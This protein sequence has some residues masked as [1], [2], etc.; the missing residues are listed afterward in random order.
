[1]CS[2]GTSSFLSPD[3]LCEARRLTQTNS[4]GCCLCP[5]YL[6]CERLLTPSE[7]PSKVTVL[8]PDADDQSLLTGVQALPQWNAY[9]HSPSGNFLGLINMCLFLPAIVI[10]PFVD[11][12]CDRW[13]KRNTIW[14]G[15]VIIIA[16]AI[17]NGLCTSSGQFIGGQSASMVCLIPYVC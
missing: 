5:S 11:W 10:S 15:S 2:S 1:M 17:W 4:I 9:F 13:G 6:G 3:N 8:K 14:I 12:M 7:A 16:G